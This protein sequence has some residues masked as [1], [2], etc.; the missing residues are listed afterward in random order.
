M[1]KS[2]NSRGLAAAIKARRGDRS[3]RQVVEEIG[4]CASTL[5][6]VERGQAVDV[7]TYLR[8]CEW[9]GVSSERFII[10]EYHEKPE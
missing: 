10:K 5:S 2:L 1:S 3:L 7:P 8:L 4:V 9:L 6:R